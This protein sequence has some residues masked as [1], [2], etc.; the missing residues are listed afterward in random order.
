MSPS[1]AAGCVALR[2]LGEGTCEIK[3]LFVALAYRGQ[4][5]GRL[6]VEEIVRRAERVGYRRMV[7]DTMP[8]MAGAIALYK[9]QEFVECG[10]YWDHPA[11]RAVFMERPLGPTDS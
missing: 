5:T 9:E 4:G 7:L 8:D 6:L 2:D 11:E 3:R 1:I 10:Q